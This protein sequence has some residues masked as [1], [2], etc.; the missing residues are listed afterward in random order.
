MYVRKRI[1]RRRS[2]FRKHR[3]L[4]HAMAFL[5]ACLFAFVY[6]RGVRIPFQHGKSE[7]PASIRIPES[8]EKFEL[9][10]YERAIYPYSV[11][12]GGVRSREELATRM[13]E[14]RVIANHF[15]DFKVSRARIV[16]A[17]E[18]QFVHVSYR[19]QDQV[20][21]TAKKVKIPEGETLIT[22][23][24]EVARTRCGN[25][26]SA[27]PMEP[28]SDEEPMVETLDIPTIAPME[29]GEIGPMAQLNL[30]MRDFS[31]FEALEPKIL[32]YY[33]RPLFVIQ[34]ENPYV[35][36]PGTFALL[37]GGLGA[38]IVIRLARKK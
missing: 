14:D 19:M 35:P 28:V 7:T 8:S 4:L 6:V 3:I 30:E 38:F 9:A 13:S 18:T 29:M 37:I 15:A 5:C 12:P 23:G 16:K 21:W 17:E 20:F 36:E 2:F 32:P 34:P 33:F 1:G 31:P 10:T 24:E 11:I 27:V 25:K 22:D 26:V